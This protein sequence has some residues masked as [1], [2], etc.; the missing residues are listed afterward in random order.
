MSLDTAFLQDSQTDHDAFAGALSSDPAA[1]ILRHAVKIWASDHG[2]AGEDLSRL[3]NM[4]VD[5]ASSAILDYGRGVRTV[6]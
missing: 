5:F 2:I 4:V 3:T 1:S 6:V